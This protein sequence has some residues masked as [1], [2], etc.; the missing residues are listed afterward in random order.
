LLYALHPQNGLSSPTCHR[1]WRHSPLSTGAGRLFAPRCSQPIPGGSAALGCR[2]E[3]ECPR[4]K[5]H[6]HNSPVL[7]LRHSRG[8]AFVPRVKLSVMSSL[9]FVWRSMELERQE[10]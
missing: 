8:L 5:V 6:T 3:L 7:Y 4:P 1:W 9:S 10:L 2:R